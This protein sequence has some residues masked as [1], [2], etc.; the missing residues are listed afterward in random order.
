MRKFNFHFDKKG[1]L[2]SINFLIPLYVA[3]AFLVVGVNQSKQPEGRPQDLIGPNGWTHM[4]GAE[5]IGD[6][7]KVFPLGRAIVNQ[8]GSGGR[9]NPPV[10]VRGRHLGV[11]G[12]FQIELS[13]SQMV[14]TKEA[15][16]YLYSSV[17]I[18]YDE[19]RYEPPHLRL[20]ISASSLSIDEWDGSSDSASINR[21]WP[22]P[23]PL[24]NDAKISLR[25]TDGLIYVSVNAKQLGTTP[26]NNLF[27]RGMLWIGADAA[28]GSPGWWIKSLQ[29]RAI[30][31]G[32]LQLLS[33]PALSVPKTAQAQTLR[34]LASARPRQL[35]IGAAVANYALFSDSG[36][37]DIVGS[38]FSMLTPEN[39]LKAQFIHP[40]PSVYSFKEADSL[41]DFGKANGMVI[42]G[43]NLVFSEANPS[44]MQ[45]SAISNRESIMT[46]HIKTIVQHFGSNI[47]EW[48][49][50]DEPLSDDDLNHGNGQDL[51]H[52]IWTQAM[53]EQYIDKAFIAARSANPAAKLYLNEYGL[54]ADGP[55]WDE[56]LSLV[57]RLQAR[58]VPL[59]GVGFQA[60]VYQ[61]GDEV[62]TGVLRRHIQTLARLGLISRIS[63][64][65][66]YGDNPSHQA[67]QYAAILSACLD[68]PTC[69]SFTTWGVSDRYG[70][71]TEAHSYPL[72][73]GSDLLW[74]ANLTPKLAY[75]SLRLALSSK[76]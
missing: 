7:V 14:P 29:A 50:V 53:G 40:L 64:A 27:S 36:Y 60:H 25:F 65:D 51:R 23:S 45:K 5:Q 66:V 33:A 63:E 52:N 38:Q 26:D 17:P 57:G 28:N 74:D 59:D 54:E 9:P 13:A 56:F 71:T 48:D 32:E 46:Q 35:L 69:T 1:T 37:R 21:S 47:N 70:S 72:S 31:G 76:H 22:L 39:E 16:L 73:L 2:A 34:N 4:A 8:D 75:Q 20:G 42:H 3:L 41:V 68:E 55:R 18:I 24:K 11:R 43:H 6:T 30:N 49:V 67:D 58:N 10:N 62:D 44:W 61:P 12:D 15:S 19:W